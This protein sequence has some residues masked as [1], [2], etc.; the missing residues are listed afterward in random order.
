MRYFTLLPGLRSVWDER[1]SCAPQV[2]VCAGEVMAWP[3]SVAVLVKFFFLR[4]R[5]GLIHGKFHLQGAP[6]VMQE[7]LQELV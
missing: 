5:R 1:W 2:V 7:R 3:Y 4:R 6:A